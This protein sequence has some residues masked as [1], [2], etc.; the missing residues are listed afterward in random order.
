MIRELCYLAGETAFTI[1]SERETGT[2]ILDLQLG[3]IGQDRFLGHPSRQIAEDI[4]DSDSRATNRWLPKSN[5]GIQNNTIA[6]IGAEGHGM[7]TTIVSLEGQGPARWRVS[8]R[9]PL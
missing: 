3:K 1:G 8:R 9:L 5:F 6:V 4:S 7:D 2:N